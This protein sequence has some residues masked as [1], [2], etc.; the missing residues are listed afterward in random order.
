MLLHPPCARNEAR[1]SAGS[2]DS[3]R[4]SGPVMP[5]VRGPVVFKGDRKRS[6]RKERRRGRGTNGGAGL[7]LPHLSGAGPHVPV[8]RCA[9]VG[10]PWSLGARWHE[11]GPVSGRRGRGRAAD[12][13]RGRRRRN[14]VARF[15]HRDRR[16]V[17]Q[18]RAQR[19]SG[20]W[21]LLGGAGGSR[22]A[23]ASNRQ[24]GREGG[25]EGGRGGA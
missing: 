14:D 6:R 5:V 17:G 10:I 16:I 1:S 22:L 20:A 11:A 18:S 3:S 7:P 24:G 2:S 12:E 15:L 8:E 23:T 4:N 9:D 25:R 21:E 19:R 13:R